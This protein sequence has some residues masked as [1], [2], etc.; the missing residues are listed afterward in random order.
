MPAIR[1]LA[2]AA[3]LLAAPI[4]SH[5]FSIMNVTVLPDTPLTPDTNVSIFTSITTPS[6][7]AMLFMPT[8]VEQVGNS[9]TIDIFITDGMILPA[10]D[11]LT[12]TVDLGMLP[13]G[14][15]SYLVRITPG[16]DVNF[17]DREENGFFTVVPIPA[18]VWFLGGA[19]LTLFGFRR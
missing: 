6:Q 14:E 19:L 2:V 17:G 8:T 3:L 11:L 18:A 5:A 1:H 12:E 9:F 7:D 16:Y 13:A 4:T 15:Y 10:T